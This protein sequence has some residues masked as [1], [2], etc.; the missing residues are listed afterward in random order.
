V[1]AGLPGGD[2]AAAQQYGVVVAE[3]AGQTVHDGGLVYVLCVVPA[4]S[5]GA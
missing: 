5:Y 3:V 4:V 1:A 2:R